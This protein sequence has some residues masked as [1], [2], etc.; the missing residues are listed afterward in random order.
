MKNDSEEQKMLLNSGF[1]AQRGTDIYVS[2][3]II[4]K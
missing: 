3:R 2:A 4:L 1:K